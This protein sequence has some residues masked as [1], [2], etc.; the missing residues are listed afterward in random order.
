MQYVE[1][2]KICQDKIVYVTQKITLVCTVDVYKEATK[3]KIITLA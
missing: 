2:K 3:T 1:R